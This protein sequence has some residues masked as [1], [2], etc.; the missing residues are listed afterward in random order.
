[1]IG[2]SLESRGGMATVEKQL[3]ERLIG[4]GV[5]VRLISTYDDC[6][7]IKKAAIALA[8]YMR[9]CRALKDVDLVHAHMAARGSYERKSIFLRRA[10]IEGKKTL[11]HLHGAEFDL[12]FDN[13]LTEKKR[14]EVRGLFDASDAVIALSEEWERWLVSRGFAPKRLVVLHNAVPVPVQSCSPCLQQNVLFLGRLAERKSPDVLLRAAR[15]MLGKYAGTK[16]VFGGDG[17]PERYEKLAQELGI[18]DRCEFLGWIA[19]ADRERLFDHAGIYCLPSKNEGMPMS[20]LEAMGHGIPTIATPVGGVPQLIKD[21]VNGF[22][23]PVGDEKK[24]SDLLCKL[25]GDPSLRKQIGA[26]GRRTISSDFNIEHNVE[27]LIRLYEG[28]MV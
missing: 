14:D 7:R 25:M 5:Q 23:M 3:I 18:A 22:L 15:E 12:W 8:A 20:V 26:A 21:G 24:L 1:M 28:L 6:G 16:L 13:E 10:Q 17:C 2:P 9:Y 4:A 11:I 19:E 27:E